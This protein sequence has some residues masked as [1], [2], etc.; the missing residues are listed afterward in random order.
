MKQKNHFTCGSALLALPKAAFGGRIF[1]PPHS[2]KLL[3]NSLA[4][5]QR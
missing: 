2:C 5:Q 3:R 1:L 4:G